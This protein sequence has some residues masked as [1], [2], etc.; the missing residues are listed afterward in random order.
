M[1]LDANDAHA[2]ALLGHVRRMAGDDPCASLALIEHAQRL[3]PRDPRTFLWLIY[4][5]SCRWKLGEYEEMEAM[6]RRS[7]SLCP[8]IGWSWASLAGALAL[9][10]RRVEAAEA[11]ASTRALMPSF[12]LSRFH[13]G[14][15]M[16][17]GR[18]FRGDV[19]RDYRD[20]RDALKACL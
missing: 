2:L 15:R 10:D 7:L 16:V 12:T 20:F 17:Y 8:N 6:S 13:W 11:L 18:R 5:A 1:R 9:Q 4:G 19:E 14:A 3:S